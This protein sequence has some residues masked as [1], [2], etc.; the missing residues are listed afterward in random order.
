[1]Q[2]IPWSHTSSDGFTVRG[3][4]TPPTGKPLL[5]FLHGNG[6]CGRVYTPLL[7]HLSAHV[8]LWLSD[9]PGHGDSEPGPFFPGWNR[10]AELATE[11]F[12]AK[13]LAPKLFGP[14]R[15]LAAGHSF[16]GVL[17]ALITARHPDLFERAVLLDPVLFPP[18]M[19]MLLRTAQHLGLSHR[20]PMPRMTLKRR[21]HWASRQEAMDRLRGR[22]TYAGWEEAALQAFAD[23]ALRDAPDGGVTLKCSPAREAAIFG[24]APKDLWLSLRGVRTPTTVLHAKESFPFV[25]QSAR[26]W[27][28][29]NPQVRGLEVPGGHCFMQQHPRDSAQRVLNAIR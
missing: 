22:G 24:S 10:C 11:A 2:L 3:W 17:T 7:E 14:V 1:M 12:Q 16:G 26:R 5:L 27:Q 29:L 28:H 20:L 4:H 13:A 18:G 15:R 8:D 21:Q 9:A 6:F 25:A 23:H 19:V